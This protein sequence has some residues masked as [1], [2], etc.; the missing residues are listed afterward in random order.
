VIGAIAARRATQPDAVAI[1]AVME[2]PWADVVL[3]GA[4]TVGEL[5]SNLAA[6][7]IKLSS[8]E[9]RELANCA[10]PAEDYWAARSR[11]AWT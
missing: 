5:V 3:S 10:E 8:D 2:R 11:L 6:P 9:L 7:T 1:A 4:A